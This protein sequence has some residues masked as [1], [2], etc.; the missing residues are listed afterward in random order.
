MS[1]GPLSF[2]RW[3]SQEHTSISALAGVTAIFGGLTGIAFGVYALATDD[4]ANATLE[5]ASVSIERRLGP[6]AQFFDVRDT[7]VPEAEIGDRLPDSQLFPQDDFYAIKD[8]DLGDWTYE[9][10][11]EPDFYRLQGIEPPPGIPDLRV[12]LWRNE[13]RAVGQ[14]INGQIFDFVFIEKVSH[15]QVA[16]LFGLGLG[17][18]DESLSGDETITDEDIA[19]LQEDYRGDSTGVMLLS[20]LPI[21]LP[22]GLPDVRPVLNTVQ[23]KGNV[24]YA[25]STIQID[26]LEIDGEQ[27]DTFFIER[28]VMMISTRTDLWLIQTNVST[29]DRISDSFQWIDDWFLRFGIVGDE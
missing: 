14:P 6:D 21:L 13:E 17:P 2:W 9:E 5:K 29:P 7:V 20:Q 16:E 18:P 25:Q 22:I 1:K 12:H 24:V 26:G 3:L 8:E 23:K 15:E 4:P 10:T 11:T 28:E 19:E 27:Y